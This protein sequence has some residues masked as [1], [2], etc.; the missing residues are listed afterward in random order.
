MA[1]GSENGEGVR[2]NASQVNVP[3]RW[4]DDAGGMFLAAWHRIF[5]N[6]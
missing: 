1:F 4:E 5:V 2:E 3:A 6:R